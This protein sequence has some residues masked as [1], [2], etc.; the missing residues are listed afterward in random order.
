MLPPS[1]KLQITREQI[2]ALPWSSLGAYVSDRE[3]VVF[4]DIW[5]F[6]IYYQYP[7]V[8]P[9]TNWHHSLSGLLLSWIKDMIA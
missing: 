7:E 4:Q 2:G 9:E 1:T 3:K 6:R 8:H 5:G